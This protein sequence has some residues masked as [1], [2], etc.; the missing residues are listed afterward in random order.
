VRVLRVE[1][2]SAAESAGLRAG[3]ELVAIG[4]QPVS[5][6]LDVVYALGW[7][8]E[9]DGAVDFR[10]TRRG[11]SQ[12]VRLPPERPEELGLELE[13]DE[14]RS[15]RNR[16]IFCFIDQLPKGLRRSLSFRDEDYRL[17]FAFG[18]Y[19]T[20]TNLSDGDYERIARQR[21]SPLY[22]SV[23]ATD[24]G[25]RRS[26]LGNPM[27]PSIMD[28]LKRLHE[29]G[30]A[31]HT[32]IVIVPG[33]NDG[34]VLEN[35]LD[36]LLEVPGVTSIAVVPVGL[37][38]HR[39]GLP[40][41]E[42]VTRTGAENIID[43]IERRQRALIAARGSRTVFG[44]DELYLTA[45]RELPPYESYEDLPQMENGVGLLR[46]LEQGFRE[47]LPELEKKLLTLDDRAPTRLRLSIVTGV[48][49]AP[50]IRSLVEDS[51]P[52]AAFDARVVPVENTLFGS[53]VTVAGLLSG[54]DMVSAAGAVE[55]DLTLVPAEAFNQD[56]LTIDDMSL[57]DVAA[58]ARAGEMRLSYD[59]IDALVA[60]LD[61]LSAG[62][63][64]GE[65]EA[66]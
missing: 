26:M 64:G 24:D 37:T 55:S 29:G 1:E 5:D 12:V 59:I 25:V 17:S 43:E 31:M 19:I 15:C 13:Q 65:D 42:A 8:E 39:K 9:Q 36:D 35:T 45:G 27:A 7:C 40:H 44:V 18:N 32:Q 56:G 50:F 41:I 21:L 2:G 4:G 61:D 34:P 16:C 63:E 62:I 3:D 66:V 49:A 60:K 20:L 54:K 47:G 22:I 30:I 51:L 38:A 11:E 52:A 58:A 28:A 33:M 53:E 10:L 46:S 6:G 23:H 57:P 14:Y 48:S